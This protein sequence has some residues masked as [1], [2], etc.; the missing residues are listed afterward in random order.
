MDQTP[1]PENHQPSIS[2]PILPDLAV[3]SL[4]HHPIMETSMRQSWAY[5]DR[6]RVQIHLI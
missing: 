3:D 2:E 6:L 4:N 5:M 1:A